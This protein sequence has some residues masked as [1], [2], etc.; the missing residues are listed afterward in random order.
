MKLK[1]ANVGE[2]VLTGK[3]KMRQHE[4]ALRKIGIKRPKVKE[5]KVGE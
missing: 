5:K 4:I 2:E 3:E 1:P